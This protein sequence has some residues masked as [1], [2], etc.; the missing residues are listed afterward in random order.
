MF[1][2]LILL[3]FVTFSLLVIVHGQ[4]DTDCDLLWKTGWGPRLAWV[5]VDQTDPAWYAGTTPPGRDGR[6]AAGRL[7]AAA[8]RPQPVVILN[9]ALPLRP[10]LFISSCLNFFGSS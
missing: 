8:R 5:K 4:L 3:A 2:A 10:T 6:P 7:P 9:M 1:K